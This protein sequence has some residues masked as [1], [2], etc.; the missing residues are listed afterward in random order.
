MET[1]SREYLKGLKK[2]IDD[3]RYNDKTEELVDKISKAILF[4]AKKGLL[5]LQLK[6]KIIP[7]NP[8]NQGCMVMNYGPDTIVIYDMEQ[9]DA[10]IQK[11]KEKFFDTHI[12]YVE[13]KDLRGN[14]LESAIQVKWD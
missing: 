13:S 9:I 3:K 5:N 6:I 10:V 8:I 12:E 7:M 4:S 1:Y 2:E 11:L 14:I